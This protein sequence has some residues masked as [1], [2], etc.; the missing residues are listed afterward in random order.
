MGV[1]VSLSSPPGCPSSLDF[2]RAIER[3]GVHLREPAP[4]ELGLAIEVS[5]GRASVGVL[6]RLV[7]VDAYGRRSERTVATANCEEATE[8]LALVAALA[9]RRATAGDSP[10]ATSIAPSAPPSQNASTGTD[11]APSAPTESRAPVSTLATPRSPPVPSPLASTLP[12]ARSRADAPTVASKSTAMDSWS[13]EGSAAGFGAV[14]LGPDVIAG[15]ALRV[16]AALP[17]RGSLWAPSVRLA[18]SDTFDQSLTGALGTAT[19][20]ML[21]FSTEVCPLAALA[22]G[23]ALFRP[24][25]SAELGALRAAGSDTLNP[26]TTSRPWAAGGIE[27]ICAVPIAGPL[28]W[29]L[30]LGTLLAMD[31]YRFTIGPGTVYQTP[32]VVARLALGIGATLD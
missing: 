32:V 31:R 14:G 21:A 30:T 8:A 3:R 23:G 10:A 28:F 2:A 29:D 26:R 9:L 6:G 17:R 20:G 12:A 27:G 24:C 7:L 19:F 11:G 4:T 5:V 18:V 13:F 22:V 15:G 25:A 16:G 1:R